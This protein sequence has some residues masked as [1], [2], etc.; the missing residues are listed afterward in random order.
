MEYRQLGRSGLRVSTLTLGT[1]GFGGTGW[2]KAVGTIDVDGRPRAD[3]H[4]PRGG[5]Q[6]DRHRRRLLRRAVGGDR[7]QG[8]GPRPRRRARGHQGAHADG[9]RRQRR[10]PLAPPRDPWLPRPACAGWA[11]TTST[12]TRCTSGTGDPAR[13]D[14]SALDHLVQSGKV[15]YIGCSNYAAWQL[16]KALGVCD[17]NGLERFVSQ[18]VYYSLQAR[19]IETEIVPASHRPGPRHPG[20][21]PDRGRAAVGQVPARGATAPGGQPAPRASGTSRPSTTRTSSTTPSSKLVEIG[22]AHGVS[23]ARVALAYLLRQA[24]RHVADRRCAHDGAARR[25]PRRR[26][27]HADRRR[28]RPRWTR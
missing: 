18:Q 16:M 20:V 6:P 19:D 10:R 21:E 27:A 5:R 1:M 4:G 17:R 23:A 26:R 7:R 13:G 24:R 9:P 3:R 11:P 22:E 15:R 12:S 8:A 14:A 28:G 2:A 25:Q